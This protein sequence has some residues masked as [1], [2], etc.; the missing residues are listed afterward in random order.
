MLCGQG[1]AGVSVLWVSWVLRASSEAMVAPHHQGQ[2]RGLGWDLTWACPWGPR[3]SGPGSE[4]RAGS[5]QTQLR[6]AHVP[7]TVAVRLLRGYADPDCEL[8]C[9]AGPRVP[10]GASVRDRWEWTGG[11]QHH[12][13]GQSAWG[14]FVLLEGTL[15]R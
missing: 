15:C 11:T 7:G 5:A 14:C 6:E 8:P 12:G 2:K 13:D 10:A 9:V 1:G 4:R 3:L